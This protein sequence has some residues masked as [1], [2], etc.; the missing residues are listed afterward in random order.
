[1]LMIN[2][3]K[4]KKQLKELFKNWRKLFK[5][6]VLKQQITRRYDYIEN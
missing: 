5:A 3:E 2:E 4:K 6:I 1:M